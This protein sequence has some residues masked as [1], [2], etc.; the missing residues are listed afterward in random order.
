MTKILL[1]GNP[2]VGKSAVFSRLTGVKAIVS[3]YPGT[4]VSYTRGQMKLGD[5]TAE[6]IDVPGTYT[7]EPT[8]QAE[9]IALEMLAEG[10]VVVNVVNAT[11]L[12]RNLY[13]TLQLLEKG[14]PVVVALN[15]WDDTKHLGID[16]DVDRLRQRLGVP[17]IPTVAVTGEGIKELV[18]AIPRAASP[19]PSPT[20]SSKRWA[21]V[22]NIVEEVQ[23]IR[24]RHHTWRERLADASVRPITGGI[25]AAV[26]LAVAFMLV[27]LISE[28]LINY[29]LDPLFNNLWT[30]VLLKLSPLM[31]GEGFLHDIVIGHL[32]GGEINFVESFGLLTSGLYVPFAMVL[33]YV[34][35][36]YFVLG[37]MED[38]GYLPRLAVLMDNVMHRLGLHGF[39]I[40]PTL[41]GLGCNVPAVLGTRI[42]ESKRERFIAATLISIAV[43]CA[44]LQAMIIGLVGAEGWQYVAMVYGTLFVVWIILGFI[45][46]RTVKGFSPE[47]L[48]EIPP[49]RL[50][51]WRTVLQK[52]WMRTYGFLVEA[53]PI[54]LGAVA[55]INILYFFG[56][57]DAIANF[58]APV[59]T[60]LLGLPKEAVIAIAI[61]FLRKDVAL[62]LLAPLALTASQLVV[63]SVVLAMS[64]PCIATF[65]VLL[66]E[67]GILN[68]LKAAG[69]MVASALIVGGI[70]NL[71]L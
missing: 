2:N 66:R 9:E 49:Y 4:T 46:N 42:L 23:R 37:L 54:I 11:N 57:F 3:N 71:I 8:S 15:I 40:I 70:L 12:E 28:G 5:K 17:V 64:F 69:I 41:L 47:L 58:A 33:P 36:F 31:G 39:A 68:M 20:S 13:L 38:T 65:V 21:K 61:G 60:G 19:R 10:D 48:I 25:I 43:P 45:L 67:L 53:V 16:I 1:M 22:G 59:V 55:A 63:G 62:G 24:H 50:P 7:L 27:R 51:P 30:P 14:I 56:V 35:S 34:I 6:V 44:A 29:V 32:V 18:E 26:V 52:L